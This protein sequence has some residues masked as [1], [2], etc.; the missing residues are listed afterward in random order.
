MATKA[1]ERLAWAVDVL[2]VQPA[3]RLLEVG[4]GHGVAVSLVCERLDRGRITAVDR[5][6]KMIETAKKR[7]QAHADKVR[8]IASSLEQADLGDEVYDKAF[9]VHVAA[10]H[11]P[12]KAL[13]LVR[14]R[15][16]PGGRLYLFS[17]APGW[18]AREEAEQ[19]GGELGRVLGSAGFAVEE[20]LVKDLG[21]GL[22][23]GVMARSPQ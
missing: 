13:E 15:L 11:K 16:V 7:N 19:F 17:Q 21:T 12:G 10:L 22:V 18:K 4:C 1:S 8:L 3:D 5:S 20:V 9:A 6:S 2:A 14:Q 23:A